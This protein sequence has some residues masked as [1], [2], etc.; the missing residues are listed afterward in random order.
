MSTFAE[1]VFNMIYFCVCKKEEVWAQKTSRFRS[2]NNYFY[3]IVLNFVHFHFYIFEAISFKL[4]FLVKFQISSISRQKHICSIWISSSSSVGMTSWE[5]CLLSKY[6]IFLEIGSKII[7]M[8]SLLF[9]VKVI[10]WILLNINV[11]LELKWF[12][13]MKKDSLLVSKSIDIWL[14]KISW[15]MHHIQLVFLNLL[16]FL[17]SIL[18]EQ[19]FSL[20]EGSQ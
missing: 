10:V 14:M 9:I 17:V 20:R 3:L 4:K 5:L 7:Q 15:S 12:G 6:F 16:Y 11:F 13:I 18:E 19:L 1:K 2:F 8:S